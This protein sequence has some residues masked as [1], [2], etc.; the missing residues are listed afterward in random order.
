M[1]E[2]YSRK[3]MCKRIYGQARQV[4]IREE[5]DDILENIERDLMKSDQMEIKYREDRAIESIK[6]NPDY[7]IYM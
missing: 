6:E 1:E 5:L 2:Y 7:F 4:D 3:N